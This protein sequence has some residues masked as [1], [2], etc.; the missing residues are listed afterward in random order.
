MRLRKHLDLLTQLRVRA[1]A[2]LLELTD[3]AVNFFEGLFQRLD[4]I[5]DCALASLEFAFRCLLKCFEV[6]FREIEKGLVVTA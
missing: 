2:V 6:L 3:L 4:Q 1:D 5:A